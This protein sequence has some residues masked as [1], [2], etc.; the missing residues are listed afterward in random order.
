MFTIRTKCI[1]CDSDLRDTFFSHDYET[2]VAHY[3]VELD[4]DIDQQTKIPF[5]IFICPN[6]KTVQ[7]KYLG[8]PTEIYATNHADS[9]GTMMTNLHVLFKEWIL[10]YIS[11]IHNIIE[12]GS[13][14]G[15]LADHILERV[16]CRYY[17]IE[18]SFWGDRKNK[19]VLDDFYENIDDTDIEADTIII[20]HV[21]EHFYEPKK[22]LEKISQ[23]KRIKNFFLVWPDLE[24][25]MKNNVLHVLNTEHTYYVDNDFLT[26]VFRNYGFILRDKMFYEGHSVLFFFSR[27]ETN[28][29]YEMASHP[30]NQNYSLDLYFGNIFKNVD[31]CNMILKT[32]TLYKKYLWP[33]SIHTLYLFTFGLETYLLDGLLDNSANKIG[34]KLYGTNLEILPFYRI[35]QENKPFT[36]IIINGGVFNSEIESK[37]KENKEIK[38][39]IL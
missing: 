30:V 20:S 28:G 18:P 10:K 35:V 36:L 14:L 31:R 9:T 12:I 15:I 39:I 27:D 11:E 1:F 22:I 19:I 38:Y 7:I 33:S 5:N 32:H 24:Y 25:Y 4:S 2:Y 23:N 6:C 8:N 34:K 16:D 13:S 29:R 26:T 3:Q 37:L 17:I 21:F